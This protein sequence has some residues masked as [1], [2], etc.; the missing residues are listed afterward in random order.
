MEAPY[1]NP[2]SALWTKYDLGF[3]RTRFMDDSMRI[4]SSDKDQVE[5]LRS[6]NWSEI[7]DTGENSGTEND[8][9]V[10]IGATG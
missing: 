8:P 5:I 3:Y 10:R 6:N 1:W 9:G 2:D 7:K 4:F